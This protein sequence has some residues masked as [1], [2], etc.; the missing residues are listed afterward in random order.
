MQG[1]G[2]R[3]KEFQ[4]Y[5]DKLQHRYYKLL[6]N[7]VKRRI[8][9]AGDKL[10]ASAFQVH[11]HTRRLRIL[12]FI[13]PAD[14]LD[15]I[16]I[17]FG[18]I[19]LKDFVQTWRL[20][21]KNTCELYFTESSPQNID[22]FIELVST[23]EKYEITNI[24]ATKDLFNDYE[25]Q[26]STVRFFA[27]GF[28]ETRFK[29]FLNRLRNNIGE[30]YFKA[31]EIDVDGVVFDFNDSLVAE[32]GDKI[33]QLIIDQLDELD[34]V[35]LSLATYKVPNANSDPIISSTEPKAS[36]KRGGRGRSQ[37][38]SV[39]KVYNGMRTNGVSHMTA[40]IDTMLKEKVSESTI[41]RAIKES[42][43]GAL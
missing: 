2:N 24:E 7:H 13:S 39:F 31:A 18:Q 38:A 15:Q 9:E 1:N 42:K 32:A 22:S 3:Y 26:K 29:Y 34:K 33:L 23:S 43:E 21:K 27:R 35:E 4:A 6:V 41:Y 40:I 5:F 12:E 14:E 16:N 30:D 37:R 19:I 10:Y 25:C 17:K 20:N 11:K 36:A 8:E 28:A